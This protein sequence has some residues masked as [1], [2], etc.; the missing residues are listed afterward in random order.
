MQQSNTLSL[1]GKGNL[2]EIEKLLSGKLSCAHQ[3][4]KGDQA[5]SK[6]MMHLYPTQI[7]PFLLSINLYFCL[8][9]AFLMQQ[10][11]FA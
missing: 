2:R 7:L 6:T 4:D 10:N 9:T 5:L 11:Y 1:Q 8:S 3:I